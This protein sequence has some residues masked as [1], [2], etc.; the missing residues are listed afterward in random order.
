MSLFRILLGAVCFSV[1]LTDLTA[2]PPEKWPRLPE[3][4][5]AV[6]IP[7]QEWPLRP[8]PRTVR[9]LV[10]YPGGTLASV[11]KDTGLMLTLHNWG[12]VDFAGTADPRELADR[13]NVVAL[14]VNYLQS[15]QKEAID[16]PEPYDFGYLQALD[17]LRA[18]AF[19]F[20]GLKSA[21][22]PFATGRTYCTG[23]SGGRNVTLMA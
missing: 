13:L 21:D 3:Q 12:G 9:V 18:L 20:H 16:G 8:G 15:G 7:V 23:G 4:D 10:R 6:E 11:R 17:A 5:G 19:V 14:G 1:S 22:R 2:A